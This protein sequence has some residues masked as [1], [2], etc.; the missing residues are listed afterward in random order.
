MERILIHIENKIIR[1]IRDKRNFPVR[2]ICFD[3]YLYIDTLYGYK[4]FYLTK[5]EL[6]ILGTHLKKYGYELIIGEQQYGQYTGCK[7]RW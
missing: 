5:V 1:T 7:I 4:S 6:D 3:P 2:E